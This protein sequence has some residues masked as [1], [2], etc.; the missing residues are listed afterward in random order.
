VLSCFRALCPTLPDHPSLICGLAGCS[1]YQTEMAMPTPWRATVRPLRASSPVF[2]RCLNAVLVRRTHTLEPVVDLHINLCRVGP[3]EGLDLHLRPQRK[4]KEPRRRTAGLSCLHATG[5]PTTGDPA[6]Q[7][8]LSRCLQVVP[9][10]LFPKDHSRK[11]AMLLWRLWQ[12]ENHQHRTLTF[13]A[14]RRS[15]AF[16]R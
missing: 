14:I 11:H 5:F 16:W 10:E 1:S 12:L 6:A 8:S 9:I 4:L 7:R 3:D 13:V 15:N 2:L